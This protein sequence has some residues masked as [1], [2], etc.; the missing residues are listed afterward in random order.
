MRGLRN[1][2]PLN[3]RRTNE[4]WKG[5]QIEQTDKTFV[6]FKTMAYGYR[7]AWKVL[8]TY[9][10]N[11]RR[12][13]KPYSVRNIIGRWA[14]PAENDTDAYIRNVLVLAGLGG[15]ENMI[16]PSYGR[17][18]DRMALLIAAMTCVE[19][20]ITMDKVDMKSLWKGYDLAWP[21]RRYLSELP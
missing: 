17:C 9:W 3:I 10:L 11:F 16:R 15:N 21:G 20:G 14:P 2:N 6:Q 8:D 5:E 7:A 18:L 13:Y 12:E 1:N 19:N 4:H